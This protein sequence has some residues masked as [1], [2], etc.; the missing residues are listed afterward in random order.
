MLPFVFQNIQQFILKLLA[1]QCI[2]FEKDQVLKQIWMLFY[3]D[4]TER[5]EYVGLNIL[6][7]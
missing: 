1:Y 6:I 3:M 2:A 7:K 5:N 4:L